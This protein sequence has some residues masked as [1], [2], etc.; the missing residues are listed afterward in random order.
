MFTLFPSANASGRTAEAPPSGPA[1]SVAAST[2]LGSFRANWEP[3]LLFLQ[4]G[5]VRE[6]NV[7]LSRIDGPYTDPQAVAVFS[8]ITMYYSFPTLV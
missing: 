7:T 6:Y 3:P 5:I 2:S 1:L 4:N 8:N